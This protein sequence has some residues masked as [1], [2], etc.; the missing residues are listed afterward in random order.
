VC[1]G[2]LFRL[3][4]W[5]LGFSNLDVYLHFCGDWFA[6]T[7]IWLFTGVLGLFAV[8]FCDVW[9]FCIVFCISVYV[10]W[11]FVSLLVCGL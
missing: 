2:F 4:L 5:F 9:L 11:W 10:G 3:C 1:A 6:T 8:Y 7:W